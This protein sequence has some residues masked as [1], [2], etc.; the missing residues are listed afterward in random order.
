MKNRTLLILL[1]FFVV[2]LM[3]ACAPP[4]TPEVTTEVV[5]KPIENPVE[6]TLEELKTYNGKDGKPAYI[7]FEGKIYDVTNH[8]RW[9]TGTHNGNLAGSDLTEAI[10]AAPHGTSKINTLK[11]V[12]IIKP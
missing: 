2:L 12:G 10:K 3:S 8:P 1:T 9:A 5:S 7:A 6:L 11:E 4:P